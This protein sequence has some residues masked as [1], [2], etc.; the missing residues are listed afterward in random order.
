MKV[1]MVLEFDKDGRDAHDMRSLYGHIQL[2]IDTIRENEGL[3]TMMLRDD[4]DKV[5][6]I[7][8]GLSDHEAKSD[9]LKHIR[10]KAMRL[11]R[12]MR[13]SGMEMDESG[14]AREILM[15]AKDLIGN[16]FSK[17]LKNLIHD[18]ELAGA[19]IDQILTFMDISDR[20]RE[21]LTQAVNYCDLA[22]VKLIRVGLS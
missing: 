9:I 12:M 13:K 14:I 18:L 8:I 15:M 2:L 19:D 11:E 21:L 5:M 3:K 17:R 6:K 16:D 1:D 4:D 22:K 20:Q 10:E 7:G